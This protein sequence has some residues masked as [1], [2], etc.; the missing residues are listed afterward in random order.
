MSK[1]LK[2][3]QARTREIH[4]KNVFKNLDMTIFFY[5]K[6]LKKQYL[7]SISQKRGAAKPQNLC[8]TKQTTK[9][10]RKVYF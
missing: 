6:S 2:K 8:K 1:N 5:F 9:E 7:F 4:Y 3:M 10:R